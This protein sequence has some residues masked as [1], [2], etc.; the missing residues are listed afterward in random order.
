M[1]LDLG[2]KG[3]YAL[4]LFVIFLANAPLSSQSTIVQPSQQIGLPHIQNFRP[5]DYG[6]GY[7]NFSITQ[8]HQGLLYFG[9]AH[10]VLQYDGS[11]WRYI[12]L[13]N[14]SIA[15]S[16][17]IGPD[18]IIY[19]GGISELG[20]LAPDNRGYLQYRSLLEKIPE[21]YKDF[22]QVWQILPVGNELFFI[23]DKYLFHMPTDKGVKE[24]ST[25]TFKNIYH[26]CHVL[27]DRL[28]CWE[29]NTGL[30]EWK[31]DSF[32]LVPDGAAFAKSTIR[33]MAPL[34]EEKDEI[35]IGTVQNGLFTYD[36]KNVQ[37]F[38]TAPVVQNFL[39]EN[40]L[41][42]STQLQDG[43]FALATSLGGVAIIDQ[44]GNLIQI[45][46][47][48]NGLQDESVSET[49]VDRT[50]NLWLALNEGIS[51][52]ELPTHFTFFSDELGLEGL[53]NSMTVHKN[54]FYA[55]GSSGLFRLSKP[56][57]Q[58]Y[59]TSFQPM[60]KEGS[61][62]SL[63]SGVSFQDDFLLAS[64]SGIGFTDEDGVFNTII[65]RGGYCLLASRFHENLVYADFGKGI[66]LLQ[67]GPQG[68]K[69][70]GQLQGITEVVRSI[71][72]ESPN[73]LWIT[74]MGNAFRIDITA[75][76]FPPQI[77]PSETKSPI[78]VTTNVQKLDRSNGLPKWTS[79][80]YA[81]QDKIVFS[82]SAGLRKFDDKSQ[83]F[84]P[85]LS[86]PYKDTTRNIFPL[87]P[88]D[89][90]DIWFI[91]SWYDSTQ[92][93]DAELIQLKQSTDGNYRMRSQS[94]QHILSGGPIIYKIIADPSDPDIA[95]L[96]GSDG[97][98]K[99]S[100]T[101]KKAVKPS[102]GALVRMVLINGD[103][104]IYGGVSSSLEAS[105]LEYTPNSM[106]FEYAAPTFTQPEKT[107]YQVWLEGFDENWSDWTKEVKKD[108]TNLPEGDYIFRVRA[109]NISGI[110]SEEGSFSFSIRPPWYRT[111]WAYLNYTLLL[112]GI[113]YGL[114][115]W[116]VRRLKQRNVELETLVTE[117]T[118]TVEEQKDRLVE[119][120][121]KL[122]EL[123]Q[124]KSRFFTNISHE[125]RTP[126]TIITGMAEQIQGNEQ[127]KTLIRRN[128]R[129]LLNLV[130]Q[131]LDLRKLESGTLELNLVQG[132][133]IFYLRYVLESF[134]S[135]GESK[136]IKLHFLSDERE[137]V[138]DFDKE[139]VL[140]IVSNLLSNAIKFTPEKGDVYLF[141]SKHSSAP[142]GLKDLEGLERLEI[143]VKDTGIGIPTKKIPYIFDRFYQVDDSTTRKG[144]GT[145]IG[146][147]LTKELVKLLNGT[148]EVESE[149]RKGTSFKISLPITRNAE[150]EKIEGRSTEGGR[151]WTDIS[152]P[153][154]NDQHSMSN[155]QLADNEQLAT[156]Q[157]VNQPTLLII[158]DNPDVIE[159][160]ESLLS[161][162]YHLEIARDGQEGIETA[163][164]QIPDLILSDVMMPEKDGFEVCETLKTDER[165]SHIPIIL[166]TAKADADSKIT[167][168]QH[169]ADAYLAKPFN[170]KELF[171][172]LEKLQELRQQLQIRFSSLEKHTH[173][174]THTP[175]EDAFIEK[176]RAGIE[177]NLGN[178]KFGIPDLC[179]IIGMSRSQLHLKIKA[180][181]NRSTSHYIRA[182]RLQKAKEL[183][184]KGEFNVTEV[185]FEVGFQNRAYFSRAFTEEF[186]L[187]PKEFVKS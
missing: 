154:A 132:D 136:N 180:L 74:T 26:S 93:M 126:L 178:E 52:V 39:N 112:L 44:K 176:L 10:G 62:N 35:F 43:N 109:E 181:T 88:Q 160:L 67:K 45:L 9:N 60:K 116:R 40:S 57:S 46:N 42:N 36:G 119:Q 152:Q 184:Q 95:W 8:D 122:K 111:W 56:S 15:Y 2:N 106:R 41:Y 114:L 167:G 165:T 121:E 33:I 107:R 169:G 117:R 22:N 163:I 20:Y 147:A 4:V 99:Y 78:E 38:K 171:V 108:Y 50:G 89:N 158:E 54:Q 172:R 53:T 118:Q 115:Q 69:L 30:I 144:E 168:L 72:E 58:D 19:V 162:K 151:Q 102:F 47:K 145:G 14:S 124:V 29:W 105:V 85:D 68:W 179:Q 49:F 187:P 101:N 182:I 113:F 120:A 23:T 100:P 71:A 104:L 157:L 128:S 73:R 139:K 18:S 130:N 164:E 91:S 55:L 11:T 185:A 13:S 5:D 150:L 155:V 6:V 80:V 110:Q 135:L 146:L 75:A 70:V 138:M 81:I 97:V 94:I 32:Q 156:N 1:S 183:L 83:S 142:Q 84:V 96:S 148:I 25:W 61:V 131:I 82:T 125:L 127:A 21:A 129:S 161:D 174:P 24:M 3:I 103:S 159:Y 16:V 48:A 37:P 66:G 86:F 77:F 90:G 166:L 153:S 123:N 170:P 79:Y 134:H 143:E 87:S 51:C 173:T 31:R 76:N 63:F 34:T 133:I 92:I 137:L 17:S 140:R 175:L 141:I 149:E 177:A 59:R 64:S 27:N 12:F 98:I 7:Q 186:G 65:N 28:Y